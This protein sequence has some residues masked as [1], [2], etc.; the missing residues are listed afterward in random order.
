MKT[1]SYLL[2]TIFNR[3]VRHN[4]ALSLQILFPTPYTG[5]LCA[6]QV[7]APNV[8][9]AGDVATMINHARPKAGV[10]AVRQVRTLLPLLINC[11]RSFHIYTC[12]CVCV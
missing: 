3:F 7:N 6:L 9:A 8:F 10:F 5:K 12:S 1:D 4:K 2:M 11:E